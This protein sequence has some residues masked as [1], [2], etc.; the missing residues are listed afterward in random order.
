MVSEWSY[1]EL[2][3]K[4]EIIEEI[5]LLLYKI[6]LNAAMTVLIAISIIYD[7]YALE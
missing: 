3:K 7:K 1:S 4:S 5:F 2:M 6:V